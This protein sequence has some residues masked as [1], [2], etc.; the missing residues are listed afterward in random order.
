M[1]Q[2]IDGL[3][4][5]VCE[6]SGR[7]AVDVRG[8]MANRK[9]K[10][11]G[12]LSDYGAIYAVAKELGVDLNSDEAEATMVK[13]LKASNSVTVAGRVKTVFSEKEFTK[14]DGS[15]GKFASI[16]L[17]DKTGDVR[18]V[19]WDQNTKA[20]S[21]VRVGD[22]FMIKN[23]YAKENRREIEV[24]AGAL[25]NIIINPSNVEAPEIADTVDKISGLNVGNP[26]ATVIARVNQY[27]PM[28]D[29][30]RRDGTTG[31][32]A[33]M[34]IEDET[35]TIRAVLWD[36][37]A[38][39]K[40]DAGDTIRVDNA[41][42][43]EGLNGEVELHV[44]GRSAI[45][46]TKKKLK[47]GGLPEETGGQ[48]VRVSDLKPD[49]RSINIEARAVN[50]YEPRQYSRGIMVSM[51]LGDETGTVRA[52]FWDEISGEAQK[53]REG[54]AFRLK[55]AYTKSNMNGE[56]EVHAGKYAKIELDEGIK[57]PDGGE[58]TEGAAKEKAISELAPSDGLVKIK[59]KIMGVEERPAVY[60]TCS[61]CG[62]KVQNLGGEW[63]CDGCGIN[64]GQPNMIASVILEDEGGNVRAIAFKENAS[65]ILGMSLE[66]VMES[67]NEA[68][69]DKAP[70]E[71]AREK[72]IGKKVKL[73]GRVNYNNYSDQIEF[74]IQEILPG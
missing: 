70:V 43:R 61:D 62:K 1:T 20:I 10:T 40:V 35:G 55:D 41:Y 56:T 37:M 67:I 11:H 26:S 3:I 22:T 30:T 12:L 6:Q 27:Y 33:S 2:D 54:D 32:R 57:L 72:I 42:T 48:T 45:A 50:V 39:T 19:L 64:E 59:G 47:L 25:T 34:I 13:D 16:I 15:N 46:K 7:D 58:I 31:Y 29:F 21:Q 23:G 52:V 69:D 51:I 66:E 17:S 38:K 18:V 44:G 49:M 8:R 9:D 53:I 14:K 28:T 71:K 74:I 4:K 73:I 60:F 65:K 68:E 63:M 24:H 36:D 5:K